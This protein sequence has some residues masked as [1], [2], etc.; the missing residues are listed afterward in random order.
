MCATPCPPDLRTGRPREAST[1]G[2]SIL[3][4]A[5]VAPMILLLMFAIFDFARM[6]Y[7]QMN[8]QNAVRE[9]GRYAITGNHLADPKHP[10][11]TLS[12]VNSIIQ[13]ARQAAIGID[14]SN[15]QISSVGGGKGSAGGPG[16]TMTISLTTNLPLMTPIVA[17]FFNNGAYTFTVGVTLKNEPFPPANTS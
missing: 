7:V 3:E 8:L 16:D 4:F 6:F 15:M 11:Q 13:T 12:R 17:R 14:V 5:L 1:H 9:A 10:G 2:T